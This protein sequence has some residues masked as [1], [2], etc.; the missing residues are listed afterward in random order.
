MKPRKTYLV[1]EESSEDKDFCRQIW[2]RL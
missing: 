2:I 1:I